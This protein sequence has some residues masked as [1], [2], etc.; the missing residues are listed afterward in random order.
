MDFK[1]KIVLV[2]GGSRGIG[3]AIALEFA[4]M[5]AHIIFN[6]L[7]NHLAATQ[8]ESEIENMGVQCLKI[9]A[10]LGN[11]EKIQE[12][13]SVIRERFDRL[14]V[15][16]NNAASGVQRHAVDL[17]EKHWDWAMNINAK[18]PWLCSIEASQLMTA[19]SSIVNI[20][21]QGSQ[22]VLPF[23]LSVGTSKA[24]LESLTRYL[25]VELAPKGISVNAVSGGYVETG[26]LDYFPNKEKMTESGRNIP[27]GR[28][29]TGQDIAKVVTFLC[30]DEASMI[31]GQV[32]TVDGGATLEV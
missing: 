9:R 28:R 25:A 23:Y 16:V 27:A 32:I 19:G 30:G 15:L 8:T 22:K 10:H 14:D 1:D 2:T 26:A 5:G 3:K 21:S 18:A 17:E 11:A 20:T 31:R 6:Y 29:L 13:F 24:A 12:M 7:R 4:S